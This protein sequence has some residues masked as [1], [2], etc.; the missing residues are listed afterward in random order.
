MVQVK[1]SGYILKVNQIGI[2]DELVVAHQ[3]QI[4][5]RLVLR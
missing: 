2:V 5:S 3:R 1:I 4:E